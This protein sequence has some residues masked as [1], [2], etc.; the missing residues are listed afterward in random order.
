MISSPL[1]SCSVLDETV[2]PS[3]ITHK[4]PSTVTPSNTASTVGH[5][6]APPSHLQVLAPLSSTPIQ[7]PQA[8]ALPHPVQ[9]NSSS[10]VR[11]VPRIA[12]ANTLPSSQFILP[13]HFPAHANAVIVTSPPPTGV[14]I[15]PSPLGAAP[16]FQVLS[17]KSQQ[18]VIPEDKSGFR[19]HQN[20]LSS[21]GHG[22]SA[23]S[24]G[25]PC[26]LDKVPSP[27]SIII[28]SSKPLIK[29]EH[30]Q[31]HHISA[32]QKRR[33]NINIGF[34]TL[35]NLVP[36]LKSQSNITNAVTLQKTVEHIGKLQQERQ[37]LQDEVRRLRE[38]IE[39]LNTSISLCQEQLP[40]TGVPM[41]K[42]RS[43]LMQDKF[44]EYVKSRTQ[45]NW[46][47]WIFSIIIKPLFDSFSG[48]VSMT[49]T[50]E[51]CHTTLQW[52]DNHCSL[53]V[54]RPMVLST[55]RQLCTTTSILSDPSLL[56]S[57]AIEA[58]TKMDA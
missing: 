5:I 12:P 1:N 35:C 57:E 21:V 22:Q 25:S 34:K 8:F 58:A 51:L 24:Q 49:S 44:N 43:D 11:P 32:E 30:N 41:R 28:T 37:Q 9:S 4:A 10:K 42:N 45:Q 29:S 14:V 33:S 39:E 7:H 15:T 47:F 23:A 27:Q 18:H 6:S 31:S 20:D 50:E 17:Q 48:M 19:K 56:P 38:E 54:L 13:A 40:A 2:A 55:L 46:K 36:T 53:P 26:G 3:V 16:G 52:F